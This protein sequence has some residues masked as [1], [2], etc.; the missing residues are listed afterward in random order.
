VDP[1]I[2]FS[3]K[4]TAGRDHQTRRA[5]ELMSVAN[6]TAAKLRNLNLSS[7]I[8]AE[9][10]DERTPG[11]CLRVLASGRATWTLRYRP[12]SGD[13]YK[14]ISLGQYPAVG[15]AD[16]RQRAER[17]RV[18][19][20]DGHD[21][22]AERKAKRD[23]ASLNDLIE[24]YLVEDVEPKK[25]PRTFDLY[26]WYFCK[27]IGPKLGTRK[28]AT[29]TRSDVAKLHRDIGADRPATANRAVVALSGVFTYAGRHNMVPENFNP[30]RGIEKFREEAR[31]R[32]L[33]SEELARLGDA[34]R[35]AETVGLP[36]Q[37][38]ADRK[39][40]RHDRRPE[41]WRS[42]YSPY[43]T[44]AIRLLLFTGCRLREILHLRWSEIDFER[45]L[46]LL[47]D[48]KTGRKVVILNTAA[49][50]VLK[51]LD[52]LGE[53]VI[54][55]DSDD[56]PRA[57]LKR[58]WDLV[59]GYARLEGVRIHDLRH[60][61]ASIGAGAGLGLPIIGKLL[62]HRHTETTA[63]YAHL[64]ADPLR[65]ASNRIA[66]TIVAAMD[67]ASSTAEIV[68]FERKAAV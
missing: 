6:L 54:A 65:K 12:H 59:T 23:S 26:T 45:G 27:I 28:A 35:I 37:R 10:W 64:D 43:V 48:S 41:N 46:L 47:P 68:P 20:S 7:G 60:T 57:D 24:R 15:L 1:K 36:W 31:E 9:L 56:K 50:D 4:E 42:V 67:K 38:K 14:R 39:P 66:E 40:S 11:L 16:A 21:P 2:F 18:Q 13:G 29:I 22:Q 8:P 33:T 63:R 34:L 5:G 61:H 32:Y 58:P 52:P 17:C 51:G 44:A 25:K 19:V 49:L 53:Y 30:A 62:G 55:G 3:L